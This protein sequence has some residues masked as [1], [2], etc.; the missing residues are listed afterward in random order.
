[1]IP[2]RTPAQ[3]AEKVVCMDHRL[4]GTAHGNFLCRICCVNGTWAE[5]CHLIALTGARITEHR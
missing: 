3:I 4:F 1:M 5:W 2:K